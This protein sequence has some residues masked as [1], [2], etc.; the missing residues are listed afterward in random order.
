MRKPLNTITA[1]RVEELRLSKIALKAKLKAMGIHPHSYTMAELN[2]EARKHMGRYADQALGN[3]LQMALEDA[4]RAELKVI[5]QKKD[6]PKSMGSVV[7]M[8]GAK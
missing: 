7:Q 2:A 6:Q 8:L 5:A 1:L 3:I 4:L